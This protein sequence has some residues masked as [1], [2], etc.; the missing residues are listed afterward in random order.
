MTVFWFLLSLILL[1]IAIVSI[2]DIV[3][4]HHPA[5]KTAGLVLLVLI[6][7]VVGPLI[8]W[9]TRKPAAGDA[10]QAYLAEADQRSTAAHQ[11]MD[12]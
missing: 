3:G 7:P 11:R 9:L 6:L 8:Y 1:A 10:E 12:V 2:V 5:G 4:R